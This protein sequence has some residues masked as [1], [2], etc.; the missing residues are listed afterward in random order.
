MTQIDPFAV[1]KDFVSHCVSFEQWPANDRA[2]YDKAM[3]THRSMLTDK[4]TLSDLREATRAND[5][6]GYGTWL[7]F[8]GQHDLLAE[9][10]P[11]CDRINANLVHGYVAALEV[12][13]LADKSIVMYLSGTYR[14][15]KAMYPERDWCW[16]YQ[17]VAMVGANAEPVIDKYG[18]P[19]IG[20][21]FRYGLDLIR[22]AELVNTYS[23]LSRALAARN[24]LM[25]TLLACRPMMRSKNLRG[26]AFGVH[27]KREGAHYR[28]ALD[29]TDRKGKRSVGAP[30]PN[31]LTPIIDRYDKEYLPVFL[32]SAKVVPAVRHLW[33]SQSG[34]VLDRSMITMIFGALTKARFGRHI[35][36]HQFRNAAATSYAYYAPEHIHDLMHVLDHASSEMSEQYVWMAGQTIAV[37]ALD[38]TL[39]KIEGRK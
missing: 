17:L 13:D 9:E 20:E 39:C 28:L 15:L 1:K 25:F 30:L 21:L 23:P 38:K 14:T 11:P 4:R 27:L 26:L 12:A 18:L 37:N 29:H 5:M 22:N 3:S 7:N 34:E 8:L 32:K 16:L 2:I 19:S 10:T 31:F 6:Y 35:P 33:V 24:S 36:P